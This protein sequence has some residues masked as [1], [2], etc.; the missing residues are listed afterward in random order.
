MAWLIWLI[1]VVIMFVMVSMMFPLIFRLT[2]SSS[3]CVP[4]VA[5][6]LPLMV[7]PLGT[8]SGTVSVCV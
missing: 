3:L 6:M 1:M 7:T 4:L 5:T 2:G 8:S